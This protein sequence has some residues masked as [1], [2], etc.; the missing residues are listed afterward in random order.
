MTLPNTDL[1]DIQTI[2]V[3][4]PQAIQMHMDTTRQCLT[5]GG[6]DE[7]T[8]IG[9]PSSAKSALSSLWIDSEGYSL[10]LCGDAHG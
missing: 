8:E 7:E 6:D 4:Q 10:T 1:M 2:F 3:A 9:S 5:L